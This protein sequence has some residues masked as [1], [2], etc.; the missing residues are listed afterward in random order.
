[1]LALKKQDVKQYTA[2]KT[3]KRRKV[4]LLRK[5]FANQ[6]VGILLLAA[7]VCLLMTVYV[8]AYARVTE[9]G[10]RKSELVSRLD[11]LQHE[12]EK[13]AVTLDNLRQPGRVAAFAAENGMHVGDK[14][15]YLKPEGEPHLAQNTGE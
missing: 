1:M 3:T 4:H 13:L 10:Y 8:G 6:M 5:L 14:M 7:V 9:E 15:V 12:N 11:E 2:S